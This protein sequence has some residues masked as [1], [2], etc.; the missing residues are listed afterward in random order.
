LFLVDV[1]LLMFCSV[2]SAYTPIM[3]DAGVSSASAELGSM[4]SRRAAVGGA[5]PS[6]GHQS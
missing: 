2:W 1:D 6:R 3:G 4:G 5:I